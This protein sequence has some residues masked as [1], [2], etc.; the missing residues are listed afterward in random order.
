MTLVQTD[1]ARLAAFVPLT[2]A[3]RYLLQRAQ[4]DAELGFLVGP[5]TEVFRLSCLAE[6]AAT[7]R[8]VAEVEAER[9]RSLTPDHHLAPRKLESAEKRIELLEEHVSERYL[10]EIDEDLEAWEHAWLDRARAR[11]QGGAR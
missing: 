3:V 11:R 6:A 9:G 5:G 1:A 7:G 2:A 10:S 4:E 8:H